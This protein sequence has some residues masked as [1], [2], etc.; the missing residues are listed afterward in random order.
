MA[1]VTISL[2]S[3]N[4]EAVF[5]FKEPFKSYVKNAYRFNTDG[6]VMKVITILSMKDNVISDARD[7]FSEIYEPVGLSLDKYKSDVVNGVP[8]I[9]LTFLDNYGVVKYLRVPAS[10]IE[11]I[12]ETGTI[13]YI[14]KMLV[15]DLGMLPMELNLLDSLP[16]LKGYIANAVGLPPSEVK[17]Y[18]SNLGKTIS[19][20][21]DEHEVREGVRE[22]YRDY[23][24]TMAAK[25]ASLQERY[26]DVISMLQELG[27]VLSEYP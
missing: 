3:P 10:Y 25:Y 17:A 24:E 6:I 21:Y 4:T 16:E 14:N 2:P 15:I 12:S 13:P 23:T 19:L 20:P 5:Q 22:S 7:P 9:T 18:E 26:T 1:E 11:D 8:I 27:I